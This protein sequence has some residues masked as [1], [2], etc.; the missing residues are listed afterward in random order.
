MY[1]L[2][3][4][5]HLMFSKKWFKRFFV[6]KNGR[7]YYSDGNNGHPDSKEGTLSFVRSNPVPGIRHCIELRGAIPKMMTMLICL[8][9]TALT[10][11]SVAACSAPVDGQAFAFE[12]SFLSAGNQVLSSAPSR[13]ITALHSHMS[14]LQTRKSLILATDDEVTRQRCMLVI[15]AASADFSFPLQDIAFSVTLTPDLLG[16]KN[17]PVIKAVLAALGV[18]MSDPSLKTV[19]FDPPSL[20]AAGF[21]AA[22]FRASGC[23]WSIIKSAGFTISH[24]KAAGCDA[25]AATSAGYDLPSLKAA[26]F[27]AG[28]LK[29]AGRDYASLVSVGFSAAELTQAGFSSEVKV[30][31]AFMTRVLCMYVCLLYV[32]VRHSVAQ[33]AEAERQRKIREEEQLRAAAAKV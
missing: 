32:R 22:A 20:K 17:L 13:I 5:T 25:A 26:G 18:A 29:S 27:S 3:H 7:L 11:C 1:L 28:A 14:S 8:R 10:G 24:A 33:A 6:L 21:D 15:E 31:Y 30:S 2:R 19:G 9:L 23:D 4:T 16:M 12:I